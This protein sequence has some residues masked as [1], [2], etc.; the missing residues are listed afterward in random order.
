MQSSNYAI[1][2]ALAVLPLGGGLSLQCASSQRT[3]WPPHHNAWR[4]SRAPCLAAAADGRSNG[5]GDGG[6]EEDVNEDSS[7]S[8]FSAANLAVLS[9]RLAAVKQSTDDE[10]VAA[11][12]GAAANWRVGRCAQRVVCILDDWI[13]RLD[14]HEGVLA[15]G[16]YTGDVVLCDVA[17]GS[18]IKSWDTEIW[19]PTESDVDYDGQSE[20]TAIQLTS[21]GDEQL[22]VLSGDAQGAVV[23]RAPNAKAPLM[24]ATH[25]APVSAVHYDGDSRVYSASLDSRLACYEVDGTTD[26]AVLSVPSTTLTLKQPIL[27]MSVFEN[28]AALALSDGSVTLATLS[29]MRELFSFKAHDR[30][31]TTAVS[32]VTSSQLLTGSA[33]GKVRLW[34][35]DEDGDSERRCV[36]FEGHQGPVVCL[37][38][39]GDK[40]VSGSRDGSVRVWES[41]SAAS[42]FV[43]YG[44]TTYIG[45]LHVSPTCLLSDGTNNAVMLLDFTEAAVLEQ[46]REQEEEDDDDD[47]GTLLTGE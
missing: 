42:R 38:G 32:L 43:L 41:E 35:L 15:C 7:S 22:R 46:Q 5:G 12:M 40:V 17:T 9:Q 8:S 1:A 6:D 31:A 18:L 34:R 14:V 28:Y 37:Y 11:M 39:D 23:L 36:T 29:P 47:G 2:M 16:T 33:D 13:R 3:S 26:G 44:Y 45:S 21:S 24:R 30:S 4:R 25:R 27:Q 10:A 19:D 20:I